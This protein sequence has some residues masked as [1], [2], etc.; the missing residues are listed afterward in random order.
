MPGAG[1]RCGEAALALRVG[2]PFGSS[3]FAVGVTP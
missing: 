2:L 1:E 3:V